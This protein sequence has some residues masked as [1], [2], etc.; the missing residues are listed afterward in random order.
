MTDTTKIKVPCGRCD[1]AGVIP[2]FSHVMAGVCFR[3]NG[4]GF[5]TTTTAAREATTRRRERATA[6]REVTAAELLAAMDRTEASLDAATREHLETVSDGTRLE[7]M[8]YL[9]NFQL[10]T[11]PEPRLPKSTGGE[12]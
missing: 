2:H 4:A 5:T 7:Y 3:C 8:I 9:R 10:G 1:G 6:A 12:R 11:G